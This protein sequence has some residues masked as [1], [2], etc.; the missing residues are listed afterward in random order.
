MILGI[1]ISIPT[2]LDLFQKSLSPIT[3]VATVSSVEFMVAAG[4]KLGVITIFRIPKELPEWIS[5]PM[6]KQR[7]E[8]YNIDELHS[9]RITALTWSMNGL[10]LFSGDESGVVVFTEVDHRMVR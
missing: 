4:D 8:R 5:Q 10:K 6:Q 2:Y 1:F 3:C 9:S 7:I